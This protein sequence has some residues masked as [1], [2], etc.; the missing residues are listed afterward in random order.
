[1]RARASRRL[2]RP[3]LVMTMKERTQTPMEAA[4]ALALGVALVA[5]PPTALP[6]DAQEGPSGQQDRVIR[7]KILGMSC[8]FCAYGAKQKLKMLE[9][10]EEVEVDLESGVATLAME[11]G[12][13]VSNDALKE[14]VDEAGFQAAAIVRTFESDHEDWR[15][16]KM[17]GE[18]ESPGRRDRG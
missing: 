13:D 16:G 1:M 15:P 18:E 14:T 9:G 4:A 10:V 3:K 12:A 2:D 6:A 11:A 5:A 17:P 8:P 7:V